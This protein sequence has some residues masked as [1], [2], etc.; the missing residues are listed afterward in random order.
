MNH[1][2]S[3]RHGAAPS[4]LRL[5]YAPTS[6]GYQTDPARFLGK[7]GAIF[8]LVAVILSFSVD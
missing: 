1:R 6:V 5:K 8:G 3:A 2:P 4:R 7:L